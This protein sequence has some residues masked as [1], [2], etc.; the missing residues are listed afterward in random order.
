MRSDPKYK[1]VPHSFETLESDTNN[2]IKFVLRDEFARILPRFQN[3]KLQTEDVQVL[4]YSYM[5]I[6]F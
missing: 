4:P 5:D 2:G 3:I 1:I 6:D